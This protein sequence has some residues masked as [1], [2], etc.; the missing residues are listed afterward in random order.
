MRKIR[1]SKLRHLYPNKLSHE[2][3]YLSVYNYRHS[4]CTIVLFHAAHRL[5]FRKCK[6]MF[7]RPYADGYS[8]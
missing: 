6:A 8:V 4:T 1:I 7:Y 2:Q 3:V 5:E